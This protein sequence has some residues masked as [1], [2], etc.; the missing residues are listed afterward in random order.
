MK[1]AFGTYEIAKICH[2]TPPTVGRWVNLG[3]LPSFR[4]AGG[5]R[6]VWDFDLA[7]FLKAHN[8]P[9]PPKLSPRSEPPICLIVDDEETIRHVVARA[10]V[11]VAP[12]IQVHE[13]ADGFMAGRKITQ[14]NPMIVVLDLRLPGVDGFEVCRM[15]RQDAHLS[16]VKILAIS[17]YADDAMKSKI[18]KA[19]AD[20]FMAKP[21]DNKE[22]IER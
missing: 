11:K 22:L 7:A 15:I 1:R 2:V 13:A 6:R 18:L 3:K 12:Q 14:L 17:G 4:T 5:H 10:V 8:I 9:L 20:D 16:E 21:F 19:G